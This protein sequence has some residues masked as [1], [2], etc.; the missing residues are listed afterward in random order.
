M[1]PGFQLVSEDTKITDGDFKGRLVWR[2]WTHR[3]YPSSMCSVEA[4]MEF[5]G[6][7]NSRGGQLLL[8][9]WEASG[10]GA[11]GA[12][13][14][15]RKGTSTG[16]GQ[17][18]KGVWP[19]GNGCTSEDWTAGCGGEVGTEAETVL[20]TT[21]QRVRL[22]HSES[23]VSNGA[24]LKAF[25]EKIDT[26]NFIP[27]WECFFIGLSGLEVMKRFCH[28]GSH[29][30]PDHSGGLGASVWVHVA[31]CLSLPLQQHSWPRPALE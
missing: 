14:T 18:P 31:L 8:G 30:V 21:R 12:E 27:G 6:E 28:L 15:P 25:K 19:A 22:S 5:S 11:G 26:V 16:Q 24:P 10:R 17:E 13:G 3:N 1:G 4:R 2:R 9:S 23:L 29:R 7:W 20:G